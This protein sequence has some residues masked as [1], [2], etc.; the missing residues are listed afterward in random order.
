VNGV[1]SFTITSQ[2][3][4]KNYEIR[5]VWNG[6]S[7]LEKGALLCSFEQGKETSNSVKGLKYVHYFNGYMSF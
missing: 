4:F 5:R 3:G 7:Y 6:L 1:Q 2:F